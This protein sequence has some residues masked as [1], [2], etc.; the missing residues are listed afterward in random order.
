MSF[1]IPAGRMRLL[2]LSMALAGAALLAPQAPAAT[3]V[4]AP[5]SVLGF[6]PGEDRKL[7]DW[8]QV[9]AYLRALDAASDRVSV[10][11]V[12]QTTQGRPF[13]MATG[14]C[15][16]VCLHGT[17]TGRGTAFSRFR[18][19]SPAAIIILSS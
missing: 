7:A 4:P 18:G 3:S 8:S 17:A 9:L 6:V 10:E 5:E 11:E 13:V 19:S 16:S 12:G 15:S 1:R 2:A 14:A